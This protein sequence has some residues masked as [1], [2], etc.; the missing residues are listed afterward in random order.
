MC[1]YVQCR[2]R[3]I[4]NRYKEKQLPLVRRQNTP[5]H[6]PHRPWWSVE[7]EL[8]LQDPGR[9]AGLEL[10]LAGEN[11]YNQ[12]RSRWF[13]L[14]TCFLW[15]VRSPHISIC[16]KCILRSVR[17][18]CWGRYM[19]RHFHQS[20]LTVDWGKLLAVAASCSLFFGGMALHTHWTRRQT[21]LSWNLSRALYWWTCSL[22]SWK[23][24]KG[25]R[26]TFTEQTKRVKVRRRAI[27]Q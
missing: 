6:H 10:E 2:A 16:W 27:N 23:T 17:R 21:S 3:D 5:Y 1:G 22:L 14:E 7:K 15:L 13:Q 26:L 25:S 8:F 9:L 20:H 11:S 4:Q 19:F 18:I 24:V 12:L